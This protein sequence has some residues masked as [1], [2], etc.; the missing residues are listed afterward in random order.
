[1]VSWMKSF[2]ELSR[3]GIEC[4]GSYGTGLLRFVQKA[5]IEALEVT[6]PDKLDRRRRGKNDDLDAQNAAHAAFSGNALLL[7]KVETVWWNL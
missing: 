3:I 1:M 4:T 7:L 2:G 6:V 5:G